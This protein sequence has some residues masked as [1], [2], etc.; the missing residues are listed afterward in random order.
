[1]KKFLFAFLLFALPTF[2]F[3]QSVTFESPIINGKANRPVFVTPKVDGDD[4]MWEIDKGLDDW[5]KMLPA[6]VAKNFGNAKIFYAEKGTY[7]VRAWTAKVVNGKAKLS[8]V[9]I[10]TI[11]IEGGGPTPGP[12]PGP[13]PPAPVT[14]P[15]LG[16]GGFRALLI[17]E[18]SKTLPVKQSSI[19]TG[20]EIR[21]YLIAKAA[22]LG[23]SKRGFYI[24]DKDVDFSAESK[25]WGLA[26]KRPRTSVPWLIISSDKGNFEGPWPEDVPAAMQLLKKYGG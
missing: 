23:A 10:V 22:P 20:K 1:M 15:I 6:D 12:G 9:A 2:G 21:D 14:D 3:A 4:L 26:M 16:P 25:E 19:M 24:V 8:E 5:V 11:V 17:Y 7:T 18:S 13:T